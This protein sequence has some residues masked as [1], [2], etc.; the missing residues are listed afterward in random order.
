[1]KY[2]LTLIAFFLAIAGCKPKVLSGAELETKLI[3]TMDDYLHKTLQPGVSY[4]IKDVTYY[5]EAETKNYLCQFN[6]NMHF[7][8]KDTTGIVIATISNDFKTVERRQ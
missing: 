8:N 1:M 7:Q 5:P 4:K 2:F 6:V 3:S